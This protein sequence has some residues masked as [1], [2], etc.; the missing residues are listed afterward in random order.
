MRNVPQKLCNDIQ[1]YED[2][3]HINMRK[4]LCTTFTPA[5]H[6]IGPDTEASFEP[7]FL[8]IPFTPASLNGIQGLSPIASTK[9]KC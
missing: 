2:Q 5:P 6:E 9:M 7:T 3:I 8:H 1:I 4:I